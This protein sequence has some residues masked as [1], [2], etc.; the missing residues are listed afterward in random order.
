MS[1]MP[2]RRVLRRAYI[3]TELLPESVEKECWCLTNRDSD[4]SR[5]PSLDPIVQLGQCC[6]SRWNVLLGMRRV[7]SR[8]AHANDQLSIFAP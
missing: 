2:H 6:L 1:V 8:E 3:G 7:A 5:D 4:L